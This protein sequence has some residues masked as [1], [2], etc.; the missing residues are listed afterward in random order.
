M[1][2]LRPTVRARVLLI[3]TAFLTAA[4]ACNASSGP[5]SSSRSSP[6]TTTSTTVPPTTPTPTVDASA[7]PTV[8]PIKHVVYLIEENRTFDSMFGRFPGADG[9]TF[10]WDHGTRRPLTRAT[11][12]RMSGDISHCYLCAL[13]SYDGGKMDGFNQ[14]ATANRYAYTQF[15]PRQIPNYWALAK[16]YVL[17]DQFFSS[18]T[19]PSFPNHLYSIAAQSG[20]AKDNPRRTPGVTPFS[21]TF[22]C[23]A[24]PQQVVQVFRPDGTTAMVP[25]CFDFTTEGDQLSK[26]HV[27]WA[28][29]AATEHQ[30]GYI[31]SAYSAIRRY[32]DSIRRWGAH[33]RPVDG[34]VADIQANR[35]PPVTWVTPRFQLSDHPPYSTCYGENWTTK[36]VNA[37]M[38]SPIWKDTVIFLTWDDYGGFYDHVAP[39]QVDGFGFGFRVP[40]IVISPYAK[41]GFVDHTVGEFSS[42]LRFM[43]ENWGLSPMTR[44]DRNAQDLRE[45]FDFHQA[46]RPP[47]PLPLRTDCTGAVWKLAP[48]G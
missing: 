21:N 5:P 45:A 29:Y 40:M 46:P 17:M 48:G 1:R 41:Q 28:Y 6:R 8:W 15:R 30:R 24:P 19:G 38:K 32:R 18:E 44:R 10:G 12:G 4:A 16:R 31:W 35:L 37:I 20:G 34:L 2:H 42:V 25:P 26:A 47:A 33:M 36:V 7:I 14:S 23:D 9:A 39:P 3:A 43:E 22:G 11:V 27:P 13:A